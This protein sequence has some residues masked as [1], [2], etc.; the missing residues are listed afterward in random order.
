MPNEQFLRK[1]LDGYNKDEFISFISSWDTA[2]FRVLWLIEKSHNLI[3][4]EHFGPYLWNQNFPKYGICLSIQQ[5]QITQT[6]IIDQIEK[7]I[8]ELRK[9]TK[10]SNTFKEP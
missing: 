7:K 10:L 5:L 8:K 1:L 4:Q 6:F 3:S 2:N 9:K